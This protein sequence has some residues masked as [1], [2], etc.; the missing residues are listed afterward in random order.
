MNRLMIALMFGTPVAADAAGTIT[1]INSPLSRMEVFESYTNT[2]P[3]PT[4]SRYYFGV[5]W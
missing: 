5:F 4:S 1:L 2:V 3:L